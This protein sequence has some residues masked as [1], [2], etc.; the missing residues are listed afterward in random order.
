MGTKKVASEMP[1]QKDLYPIRAGRTLKEKL[2]RG[3]PQAELDKQPGKYLTSEEIQR[4]FKPR[5]K[6]PK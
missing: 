6:K 3:K 1:G 4:D 5:E 2:L